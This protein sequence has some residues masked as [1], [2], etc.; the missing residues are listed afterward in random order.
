MTTSTW[1]TI[2]VG[3]DGSASASAALDWAAK[4]ASQSG[5]TLRIISVVHYPGMPA[6]TVDSVPSLPASLLQRAHELVADAGSQAREFMDASK[7]ET[8]IVVGTAAEALVRATE[9][10]QLLVVGNRGRSE[11]LSTVLGSVSFAVA[12]HAQCPVIVVREGA[13]VVGPQH[14]V[15]VGVDGSAAGDHALDV[16]A[17]V[18]VRA[19]APLRIISAWDLP[20]ADSWAL[21]YW[22]TASVGSDWARTQHH[23]AVTVGTAA[24]DRVQSQ[25]PGLAATSEAHH[26]SAGAALN[27][28][29]HD[30]GLVVVGSRGLGGF[31]GLVLGSV[32]H[33]AVHGSACPVMIVRNMPSNPTAAT[34]T[35]AMMVD[36]DMER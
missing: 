15:V 24:V 29:S 1:Q 35:G 11:L 18:A 5:G 14:G 21:S 30:A 25:H 16:A 20:A 22:E 19:G 32:S 31:A 13:A 7:V 36:H 17:D 34:P 9:S 4:D 28:A 10:V 6:G 2:A 26:G 12:A 27:G 33:N 8:Q 3:F 23:V